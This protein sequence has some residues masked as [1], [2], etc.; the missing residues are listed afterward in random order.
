MRETHFSQRLREREE[1]MGLRSEDIQSLSRSEVHKR[2][3]AATG[4]TPLRV[5]ALPN[6]NTLVQKDETANPTESHY[7]RCYLPLLEALEAEGTISKGDVLLETTS[8]SAGISFAWICQKLG[9]A[10]H[11]F[12][13][14]FVP[15]PRIVESRRF[16]EVHLSSDR[17]RYLQACA[18]DMVHYFRENKAAL[19]AEGRG[20]WM[21]N[22]SQD[23]RTPIAF[24]AIA[25]EVAMQKP[26]IG[27]DYFIGG[28]G[29]G[30]T[31]LGVGRRVKT[32]WPDA[33]VIGYEPTRACPFY[34]AH[35]N[36][37]G[38]IAPKLAGDEEIPAQWQVHD[39]PGTGSFGNIPFPFMK[40]AIEKGV[41]DD[42]LHVRDAE[43][44]QSVRYNEK[45]T[46]ELRQGHTS[47]VA[48]FIAEQMAKQVRGK[49]FFT[50]AY[51]KLGRYGKPEYV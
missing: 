33:R 14:D 34:V 3:K 38:S 32:I 43:I 40:A 9:F 2:L 31:L 15:E 30:S 46:P 35:R 51:D 6:G 11:V 1:L 22:H 39:M 25:D 29:N 13:P 24:E 48:R 28:V 4:N 41:I 10:P 47:L 26:G 8:G 5:I 20:M 45:L 19:R 21:P 37:W 7:D 16:A 36:R 50:M 17:E 23:F 44:L 18:E 42:M 12:M 49:I 27:V